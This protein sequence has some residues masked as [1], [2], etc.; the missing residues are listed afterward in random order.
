MKLLRPLP[1]HNLAAGATGTVVMDYLKYADTDV[2][3]GY[4]VE[5]AAADGVT[6]VLLT[7]CQ[8]DFEV[9]WRPDCR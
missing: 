1:E 6:Q 5:F 3:P 2:P 9:V 8:S 4:E 7:L